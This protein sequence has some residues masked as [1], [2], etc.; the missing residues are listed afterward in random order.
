MDKPRTFNGDLEKLPVALE[1]LTAEQRWLVWRWEQR[2]K[3]SDEEV[4]WTKPPYM[5][6][7]PKKHAMSNN[8]ETWGTYADAIKAVKAGDADG[9]GFALLG[10]DVGA[11]DLDKCRDAAT[12]EVADWA[13]ELHA[14]AGEAYHEVTVSGEGTRIL[15]T[16]NGPENHHRFNLGDG[17]GIETFRNAARYITISGNERGKCAGLPLDD[18]IDALVARF[19]ERKGRQKDRSPRSPETFDFNSAGPQ[20]RDY[21]DLIRNGAPDGSDRVSCFTAWCGT[22]PA[23][24][25]PPKRSPTSWRCIPPASAP[26]TPIACTQKCCAAATSGERSDADRQRAQ[27]RRTRGKPGRRSRS[28]PASC[29]ASSMRRR[30]RYWG[31]AAKS[32]SAAG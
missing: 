23:R 21:D 30:L 6:R 20:S 11:I 5:A 13:E 7:F 4:K 24:A 19:K 14:E 29:R 1:R 25:G 12:G 10:S 31:S 3:K 15:G 9:I 17:A 18:L 28:F 26:S 22:W 16:A 2:R 27:C 8:P 32:T